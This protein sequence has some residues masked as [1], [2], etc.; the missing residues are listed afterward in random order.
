MGAGWVGSGI[1]LVVQDLGPY[2]GIWGSGAPA[3]GVNENSF[4][5]AYLS[6]AF[7]ELFKKRNSFKNYISHILKSLSSQPA[8]LL[9]PRF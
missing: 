2:L 8:V 3:R 5:G 6:A 4:N 1:V 7:T 9:G